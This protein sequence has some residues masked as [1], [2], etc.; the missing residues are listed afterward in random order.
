[1]SGMRF[2]R[3]SGPIGAPGEGLWSATEAGARRNA[4]RHKLGRDVERVKWGARTEC[5]SRADR[6]SRGHVDVG[7]I[8]PRRRH[9][10]SLVAHRLEM[11]RDRATS[12]GTAADVD[13][14]LDL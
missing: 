5:E 14:A 1:M 13:S 2:S 7:R 6:S 10:Q 4:M 3:T 8:A 12:P 11:L 9:P